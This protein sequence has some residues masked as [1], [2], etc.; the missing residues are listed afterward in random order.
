MTFFK[1]LEQIKNLYGNTKDPE[2]Q[3][4]LE[5]EES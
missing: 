2:Y 1:E 3:S 5:N 4:D